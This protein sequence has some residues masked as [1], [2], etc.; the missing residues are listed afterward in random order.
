[1]RVKLTRFA[2][3]LANSAL[4]GAYSRWA[5]MAQE[6]RQLRYLLKKAAMKLMKRQLAASYSRCAFVFIILLPCRTF[7][8]HLLT[9]V[10][11]LFAEENSL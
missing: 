2:L 10:G 6:A 4:V 3:R 1:M 5:E 8:S 9:S 7:V 11:F